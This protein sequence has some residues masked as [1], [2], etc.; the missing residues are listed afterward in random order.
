VNGGKDGTLTRDDLEGK[1]GGRDE[2]L[3]GY[4]SEG[5]VGSYLYYFL[6]FAGV[7]KL[8]GWTSYITSYTYLS[9]YL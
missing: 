8:L 9:H 7:S 6:L 4:G 3:I 2:A 1:V 5:R